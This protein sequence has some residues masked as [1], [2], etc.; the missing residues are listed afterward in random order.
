MAQ[1]VKNVRPTILIGVSGQPGTFT[2]ETVREMA[3]HV[4][5]PIILPLS[6]PTPQ[7][8]AVPVDLLAWTGGRAIVATGS[9]FPPVSYEGRTI[10]IAQCN[11]SYLFPG[12]G[13]GVLAVRAR[14]VTDEMFMA[15]ARALASASP[16]LIDPT[17]SLLPSLRD[18][19][20]IS[21]RI[22]L[23]VAAESQRQ[24]LAEEGG[25]ENLE[26][27]VDAQWWEPRYQPMRRK[28]GAGA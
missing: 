11:N 23:A 9:P 20:K 1:V 21:R 25:T 19:R 5:R 14:R 6:N 4:A 13:L 27:L 18:I 26:R 2:E 7:S 10:P 12:V 8:E 16:G 15:A 22:A 17:A 24:G 3:R 28:A